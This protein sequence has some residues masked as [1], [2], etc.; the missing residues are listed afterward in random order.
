[1]KDVLEKFFRAS[2]F[3]KYDLDKGKHKPSLN[4]IHHVI[5]SFISLNWMGCATC[6]IAYQGISG[7]LILEPRFHL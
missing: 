3:I 6:K 4:K 7:L 2:F 1:M 5:K